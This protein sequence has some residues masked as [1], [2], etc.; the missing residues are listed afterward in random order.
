MYSFTVA[1]QPTH[2]AFA[3]EVPQL[4]AIVELDEGVRMTTTLVDAA[5]DDLRVGLPVDP[6]VRPRQRRHHPAALPTDD[7]HMMEASTPATDSDVLV[8]GER[9]ARLPT[10]S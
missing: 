3:A 7:V 2:P 10:G 1:R 5:P 9:A 8:I 6:G 4:L